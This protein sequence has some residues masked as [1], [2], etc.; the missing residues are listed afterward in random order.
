MKNYETP[1][2]EVT[3]FTTDIIRTSFN[4]DFTD[5]IKGDIFDEA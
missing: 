2:L 3:I 4:N 5:P 1:N